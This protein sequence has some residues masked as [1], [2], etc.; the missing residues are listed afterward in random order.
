MI[1]G[2]NSSAVIFLFAIVFLAPSLH[3]QRP[4][5]TAGKF[6]SIYFPSNQIRLEG[7]INGFSGKVSYKWRKLEGSPSAKIISPS[8]ISTNVANLVPG[9]YNFELAATIPSQPDLR[10]TVSVVVFATANQK[11]PVPDE[12]PNLFGSNPGY[13]GPSWSDRQVYTMM[14]KAGC[15]STRS[16]IPMF[17][18]KYY[19]DSSRYPEFKYFYDTLGF[20]ENVYFLY[21]MGGTDFPDQSEEIFNGE[22]ALVP[23]GL[24]LPIWNSD[25]SV[26]TAN[27]FANYC[28][29]SV[30]VYG[31]F[32]RYYEVWN[33]PDFTGNWGAAGAPPG[34]AG[35]W[36]ENEP[37]PTD[38][39]NLKAPGQYYV[40]ML[41]IAYEVIKRYQPD[42]IITLGGVGFPSFLHFILRNTDNPEMD[43]HGKKGSKNAAYPLSGGAYF[44][45]LSFH[46]YPQFYLKHWD[47]TT[48]NMGYRRN[49]DEAIDHTIR[50]KKKF[51]KILEQF[52]FDGKLHPVKPFIC[53][54]INIPRKQIQQDI[55]G[56]EV[57]RNFAWKT[58]AQA[59]KNN[60][61]QVY[62][63][64][65]AETAEFSSSDD[66]YKLMGLFKNVLNT[67][68]GREQLT[69]EGIANKSAQLLLQDFFYD[70]SI[71]QSL[72]LPPGIE[73]LALKNR[74]TGETR[75]MLWAKTGKDLDESSESFYSFPKK[76]ADRQFEAFRWDYCISKKPV[77]IAEPIGLKLTGEPVVL[78]Q[79]RVKSTTKPIVSNKPRSFAGRDTTIHQAFIGLRGSASA[80]STEQ[81]Y[82][83][84]DIVSLPPAQG[85]Y[86]SIKNKNSLNPVVMGLQKGVYGIRLTVSNRLGAFSCDTVW[87]GVDT[88]ISIR[89]NHAQLRSERMLNISTQCFNLQIGRFNRSSAI[90]S[91]QNFENCFLPFL[92]WVPAI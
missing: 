61:K 78:V 62:W 36:W 79:S 85:D 47:Y 12:Y 39:Y 87:I 89:S 19:G 25:G 2:R 33:E 42:A 34:T 51:G 35:N 29:K 83:Y 11:V 72:D 41:R 1:K 56:V 75:F 27:S 13:Y 65:T 30:K 3:A 81:L 46:S 9:E 64:V 6:Q 77:F 17:F 74:A 92:L 48:G 23:K 43:K 31:K 58:I 59:A 16:T 91:K 32:F 53:T 40:R 15:R 5:V 22:R 80:S 49:S 52:G 55:G 71:T 60:I 26:N 10:D 73:G 14:A 63:F 70:S 4:E 82:F 45:G 68:P 66:G 50:D 37:N 67:Y 38:L 76:F 18:F 86:P 28:Y 57:Q 20:R 7:S 44:D 69:E 90:V 8:Q 84:W 21:N 88:L 24:Y 54:E